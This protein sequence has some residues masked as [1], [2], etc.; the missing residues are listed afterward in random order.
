[1]GIL[2]SFLVGLVF[3][4]GLSLS[5]MVN[6]KKV[7]GFLDIFRTWDPSLLWV[8]VGAICINFVFFKIILKRSRPLLSMIYEVPKNL[9]IDKKLIIGSMVFGVGWGL[10]GICPGPALS[11]LLFFNEK[12]IAFILSML[13]GM[14]VYKVT[15]N[16]N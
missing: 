1:M 10:A 14:L 7:I 4:V 11:N 15:T 5:G 6:P 3:S 9:K 2:I 16:G 12:V 8:M 13:A